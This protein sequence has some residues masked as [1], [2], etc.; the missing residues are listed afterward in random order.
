MELFLA[1]FVLVAV[2][3]AIGVIETRRYDARKRT[4]SERVWTEYA[5]RVSVACPLCNST[6]RFTCPRCGNEISSHSHENDFM[7]ESCQIWVDPIRA[8]DGKRIDGGG[9]VGPMRVIH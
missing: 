3:V 1:M 9:H 6:D 8:S 5:A 4:E 2:V 7:C